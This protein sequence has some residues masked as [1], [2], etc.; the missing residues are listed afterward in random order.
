MSFCFSAADSRRSLF[1]LVRLAFSAR[2]SVQS[3]FAYGVS[4]GASMMLLCDRRRCARGV[5]C[6]NLHLRPNLLLDGIDLAVDL[7]C[8]IGRRSVVLEQGNN[9][10]DILDRGETSALRLPDQL[11]VA[12]SLRDEIVDV[13]HGFCGFSVESS[14]F[15]GSTR[16]PS[17]RC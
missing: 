1:S 8:G 6:P 16:A 17:L 9:G 13:Q 2:S 3:S 7:C 11:R 15:C 10:I 4:A 12:P 14:K 5:V